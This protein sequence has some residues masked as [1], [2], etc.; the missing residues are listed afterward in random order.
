MV[1]P[2]LPTAQPE[3][4]LKGDVAPVKPATIEPDEKPKPQPPASVQA[5]PMGE[6]PAVEPA[7][8]RSKTIGETE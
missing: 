7:K 3:T 5:R 4:R 6:A 2:A 1:E 8:P